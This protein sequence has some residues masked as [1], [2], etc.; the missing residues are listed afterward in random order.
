M[1]AGS[2]L[3]RWLAFQFKS[4]CVRGA[5]PSPVDVELLVIRLV[6]T[7]LPM[8]HDRKRRTNQQAT[9]SGNCRA[10][11][12]QGSGHSLRV[13]HRLHG[14]GRKVPTGFCFCLAGC[15]AGR[16]YVTCTMGQ[17]CMR[18]ALRVERDSG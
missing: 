7:H 13:L 1:H 16:E 3:P 10:R 5:V 15:R 9:R 8:D 12:I 6:M 11:S 18:R 4:I 14:T 2:E 17:K